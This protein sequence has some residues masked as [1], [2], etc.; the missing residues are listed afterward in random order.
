[1]PSQRTLGDGTTILTEDDYAA[2]D[3]V[4]WTKYGWTKF[5]WTKFK[6]T[7]FKWTKFKW[8]D[9]DWT[10]FK[11]TKFKWTGV[12]WTKF[13]WTDTTSKWSGATRVDQVQVDRRGLDQVQVERLRLAKFKWTAYDWAK[14]KWTILIRR[15][16]TSS[17]A[18]QRA[19]TR[20]PSGNARPSLSTSARS[21][22]PRR[23]PGFALVTYRD[24]AIA[25]PGRC[26]TFV[27][28][29]AVADLREVRLPVVGTCG[30]SFV[31]VLAA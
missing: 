10:K 11:W 23:P 1:M 28:L 14:F 30:M 25:L 22:R 2:W 12:D 20:R 17:A 27:V 26:S 8:T 19:V 29:G 16:V 3:Q 7:K 4:V 31:P 9:V 24:G 6:W 13:K 18:L 15:A 5:K 21:S